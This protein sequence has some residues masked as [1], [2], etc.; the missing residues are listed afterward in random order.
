MEIEIDAKL[1]F[2]GDGDVYHL[3]ENISTSQP[4]LILHGK[5][6]HAEI[7]EKISGYQ[8]G[9]LPMPPIPV[10]SIASPL[11]RS[12]YLA[13]GLVVLGVDHPGHYLPIDH[14]NKEWYALIKQQDF[15][16][17]SVAKLMNWNEKNNFNEMGL[18]SRKYAE[19]NLDW[20]I[21]IKAL[22]EWLHQRLE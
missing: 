3:L 15:V 17:E 6:E 4:N 5:L 1:H 7:P 10:W 21:T 14:S 8:V 12:E 11:K 16:S 9:L 22:T 13:S 2:I 18:K 20:S 19:D